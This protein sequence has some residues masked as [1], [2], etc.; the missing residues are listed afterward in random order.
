MPEKRVRITIALIAASVLLA[1]Y[2]GFFLAQR[3]ER[4][5]IIISDPISDPSPSISQMQTSAPV[6]DRKERFTA[7]PSAPTNSVDQAAGGSDSENIAVDVSGAV[8]HPTL[9][10]LAPGS[11]VQQALHAAGGPTEDADLDQVNLAEKLSDGEKVFVPHKS[12]ATAPDETANAGNR[13]STTSGAAAP[14]MLS[15]R[16]TGKLTSPADGQI[17]LNSATESDLE[18]LPGVGPA[19]SARILAYR[20]QNGKFQSID[21]LRQ[22]PGIGDKKLAKL[23][24]FLIV[25]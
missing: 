12:N 11:R 6:S 5:P 18:R 1:S 21:D 10:Y 15:S 25:H 20:Q 14:S 22:V 3:T 24:P 19:M 13:L 16:S 9:Y 7:P 23:A 17:D 8:H 4:P 2:L